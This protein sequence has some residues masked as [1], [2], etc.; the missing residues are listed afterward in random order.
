MLVLCAGPFTFIF[1]MV[2]RSIKRYYRVLFLGILSLLYVFFYIPVTL[3]TLNELRLFT[4]DVPTQD[5][6][7]YAGL[8]IMG[9][10]VTVILIYLI[11]V[12]ALAAYKF[13]TENQK[14]VGKD[15]T[16]DYAYNEEGECV[17]VPY[18]LNKSFSLTGLT[19]ANIQRSGYFLN[20]V[21]FVGCCM[22]SLYA[23]QE[24]LAHDPSYFYSENVRYVV[25]SQFPMAVFFYLTLQLHIAA[26]PF[27]E[28]PSYFI[29]ALVGMLVASLALA[30][31]SFIPQLAGGPE[32][33]MRLIAI[34]LFVAMLLSIGLTLLKNA[35]NEIHKFLSPVSALL[36]WF[37]LVLPFVEVVPIAS[38][39]IPQSSFG[40]FL[41]YVISGAS[42]LVILVVSVITLIFNALMNRFEE[43]KKMKYI[44]HELK[45]YFS[46]E[47]V[48]ADDAVLHKLYESYEER[49][50]KYVYYLR[51]GYPINLHV[52]ADGEAKV[53]TMEEYKELKE[54][55]KKNLN[56][57]ELRSKLRNTKNETVRTQQQKD[58]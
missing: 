34:T 14:K 6:I 47:G 28:V 21:L 13:I 5:I 24:A 43:E 49:D 23:L 44:T 54:A 7:R 56:K 55:E 45:Q 27:T 46:A 35:N 12:G 25:Y 51:N 22:G 10:A 57:T 19:S 2:L 3:L 40:D 15:Q 16:I 11:V 41:Y 1:W 8:G 17:Y 50:K 36:V 32:V 52:A 38:V 48:E 4:T 42:A 53:V 31:T 9:F 26:K 29:V 39:F 30:G 58:D 33:I 37:L 20:A 18:T